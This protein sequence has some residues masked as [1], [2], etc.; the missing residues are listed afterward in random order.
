MTTRPLPVSAGLLLTLALVAVPAAAQ[1]PDGSADRAG[2][3]RAATAQ[4]GARRPG[5]LDPVRVNMLRNRYHVRQMESV[6]VRAIEHAAE[7]MTH[8]LTTVSPDVMAL[9]GMPRAQGFRIEGHGLFFAVEVPRLSDSMNW[10]LQVLSSDRDERT[11]GSLRRLAET[12]ADPAL[13]ADIERAIRSLE[14]Q[15]LRRAPGAPEPVRQAQRTS[16]PPASSGAPAGAS[17]LA[18]RAA[19]ADAVAAT[20]VDLDP[21]AAPVPAGSA[22]ASARVDADL[23]ILANPSAVYEDEVKLAIADALLDYALTLP[24]APGDIVTVAARD[25]GYIAFPD[26]LPEMVTV[27]LSVK[28]EDLLAYRQQ[29]I[30][31]DEAL[32]RVHVSEF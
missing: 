2:E 19:V 20:A 31:R 10:A 30:D 1:P 11:L 23:S 5:D 25:A 12:Q 28:V 15:M 18:P 9:A 26:T 27:T 6:L 16:G 17:A 14:R 8:R 4:P 22:P 24:L 21:S 29:R 32:R 7:V 3:E 13:R